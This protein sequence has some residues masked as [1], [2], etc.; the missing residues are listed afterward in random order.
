M[1]KEFGNSVIN[2]R[3]PHQKCM[4]LYLLEYQYPEIDKKKSVQ[5]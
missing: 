4:M 5:N 1:Y 2:H 3:S